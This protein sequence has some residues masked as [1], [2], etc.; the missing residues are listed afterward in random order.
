M[1]ERG[2]IIWMNEQ[3]VLRE[4]YLYDLIYYNFWYCRVGMDGKVKHAMDH[5]DCYWMIL[6]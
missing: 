1:I 4:I 6:K 5:L 2:I 3:N